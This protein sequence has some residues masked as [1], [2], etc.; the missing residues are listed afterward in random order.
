MVALRRNKRATQ[1]FSEWMTALPIFRIDHVV[2]C[3]MINFTTEQATVGLSQEN[4]SQSIVHWFL[5]D[6][7]TLGGASV[8]WQLNPTP[9]LPNKSAFC[10]LR[11]SLVS[12]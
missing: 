5:Q 3:H 7:F 12:P 8:D 1:I 4:L 6:L 9:T 10:H 2:A 11:G